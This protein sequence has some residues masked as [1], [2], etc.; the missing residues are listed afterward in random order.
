MVR[1]NRSAGRGGVRPAEHGEWI[2]AMGS[3]KDGFCGGGIGVRRSGGSA[4]KNTGW[5]L[6]AG[7]TFT[8]RES[9][10]QFDKP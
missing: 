1:M 8:G 9:F 5:L 6:I 10:Y 2:G 3:T 4:K 7:S